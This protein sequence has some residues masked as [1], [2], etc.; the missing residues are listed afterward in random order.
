MSARSNESA[1]T[2]AIV[3][4]AGLGTRFGGNKLSAMLNGRP[5]LQHVL[6][7]LAAAGIDDP[8]VVVGPDGSA[9]DSTMAWRTARRIPNPHPERGLASSLRLG[10]DA[11]MSSTPAPE[12][13]LVALGDQPL[14]DPG[15]VLQILAQPLDAARPV[16]VAR[17]LDGSRNP[18]RLEAAAGGLVSD[19]S[20][21]R[22]LGP[23]LDRSPELVREVPVPGSNPDVD[24]PDDLA[25]MIGTGWAS[26]VRAN[27][28]QVDRVRSTPDGNDFYAPVTSMFV[29]DPARRDDP[30]L[31]ALLAIAQPGD[32][33]LDIGAGAGR[34]ALPLARVVREV[35]AVDPSD[36]MLGALRTGAGGA[37]IANVRV[38]QGRWPPDARLRAELGPD[39][40]ADSVLIAHV[41]YDVEQ[42]LP[43]LDAM[44]A[45]AHQRCVAVLMTESPAAI[46]AP[47]WP[48]VH[49]EPRV[50]LPAL[51]QFL[52]LLAARRVRPQV[53][54]VAGERRRWADR[55]ELVGYL[56]RQLWTTPGTS[57]DRRLMETLDGL[58]TTGPDGTVEVGDPASRSIGVVS[59]PSR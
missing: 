24:H 22:G 54:M 29:A 40:V 28:E 33:W 20:G 31:A 10:W 34:Y 2:A 51:L 39:P 16:V 47:F 19:A 49:G 15:V 44:E 58:I 23:L 4:A 17:H 5:V 53:V 6:D 57:A 56:R 52:E 11:V 9:L 43:F 25:R 8:A 48:L 12:A 32:T 50:A 46:A 13:V 45:A 36:S 18:V 14:L 7:A 59:W 21:D 26:R 30:V 55:D 27:A 37:G 3:L 41:G 1:R 42:V 38:I 35:V